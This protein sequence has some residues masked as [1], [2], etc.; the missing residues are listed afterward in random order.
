[1]FTIFASICIYGAISETINV[2]IDCSN[3]DEDYIREEISFVNY[4]RDRNVADV[5]IQFSDQRTGGGGKEYTLDFMGQNV[6]HGKN[7]FP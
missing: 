5:H 7:V 6:F 3:C 1:M 2:Y 4:V